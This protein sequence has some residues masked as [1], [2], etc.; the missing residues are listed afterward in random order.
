MELRCS[1]LDINVKIAPKW[2]RRK[3]E[4]GREAMANLC[5]TLNLFQALHS[6][7]AML[8][9]GVPKNRQLEYPSQKHHE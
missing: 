2:V 1:T 9:H 7:F 3:I 4:Q 6:P 8:N 5:K